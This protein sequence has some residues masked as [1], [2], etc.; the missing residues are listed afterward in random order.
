MNYQSKKE[1]SSKI[2][3]VYLDA[4]GIPI[5]KLMEMVMLFGKL[6]MMH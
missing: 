1:N 3:N 4:N 6:N 2:V 5:K